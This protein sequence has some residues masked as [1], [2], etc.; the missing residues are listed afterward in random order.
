MNTPVWD[1]TVKHLKVCG[2][3]VQ[4]PGV[5]GSRR[6][7]LKNRPGRPEG[8]KREGLVGKIIEIY[9][10]TGTIVVCLVVNYQE[11]RISVANNGIETSRFRGKKRPTT[12]PEDVTIHRNEA[13]R[14]HI[15]HREFR[16]PYRADQE[17]LRNNQRRNADE[18]GI[19]GTHRRV[20]SVLTA[21]SG[22]RKKKKYYDTSNGS[23]STHDDPFPDSAPAYGGNHIFSRTGAGNCGTGTVLW[24]LEGARYHCFVKKTTPRFTAVL[25][26]LVV[27]LAPVLSIEIVRVTPEPSLSPNDIDRF[28]APLFSGYSRGPAGNAVDVQ[29]LRIRSS[30]HDGTP[31]DVRVQV[32]VPQL[33]ESQIRGVY[34]FM[35][36][37]TGLIEPCRPSREHIAGIRWGLYRAHTLAMAGEGFIGILPDYL[38]FEDWTYVQPYFHA[39]SEARIIFDA[40]HAVDRWIRPAFPEGIQGYT[41]VAAGFSQGGHAIFAAAD[42]NHLLA[43]GLPLHGVIG[44]G[45]TTEI[46]PMLLTYP[47]LTPM[48]TQAL[49]EIYG[50]NR[51]DPNRILQPEWARLLEQDT[52]RQCVGGMQ[53]YYPSRPEELLQPDFLRALREGT[54]NQYF[55]A[56]AE[57]FRENRTGLTPHGVP[58]LI[59]QGSDD[60]VIL[61]DTQL[62]FVSRLKELGNPV[63]YR[64]YPGARHDTRQIAFNDVLNWIEALSADSRP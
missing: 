48:L 12:S 35:P 38:G 5:S 11:T 44:Y 23:N 51:I 19:L 2:D 49:V 6:Y 52:T 30:Y 50:P 9:L 58:A 63:D 18:S 27:T 8:P 43:R 7:R 28:V 31:T 59:T 32:F 34:L 22:N 53:S 37:T 60:I 39:E 47:S 16:E 26:L 25:A 46:A 33:N 36:G 17:W 64:L 41:R 45:A 13:I 40:L 10:R 4:R 15:T 3:R 14:S 54:L 29:E 42:R 20:Q 21:D 56:I 1:L 62:R 61:P 55:P 24:T 57:V